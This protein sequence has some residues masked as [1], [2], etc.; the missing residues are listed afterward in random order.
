MGLSE[1]EVHAILKDEVV[2][3]SSGSPD[4]GMGLE[5]EIPLARVGDNLSNDEAGPDVS[6]ESGGSTSGV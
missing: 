6:V 4:G 1:A 5:V 3:W 2:G